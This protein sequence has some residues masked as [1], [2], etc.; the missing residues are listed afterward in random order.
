MAE[1]LATIGG[2]A[3]PTPTGSITVAINPASRALPV[4]PPS[5]LGLSYEWDHI[6]D[7][8]AQPGCVYGCGH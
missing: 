1:C 7:I 2:A 3:Y 6:E 5:F 8:P 4:I